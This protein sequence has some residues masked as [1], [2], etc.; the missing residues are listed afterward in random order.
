MIRR[1]TKDY[2]IKIGS[3]VYIFRCPKNTP[4]HVEDIIENGT[5]LFI[6][7]G[8]IPGIDVHG[9]VLGKRG[10]AWNPLPIIEHIEKSTMDWQ[11]KIQKA[12]ERTKKIHN[13]EENKLL[14]RLLV[15]KYKGKDILRGESPIPHYYIE[16][17]AYCDN[18]HEIIEGKHVLQ[19]NS[20]GKVS[21][22]SAFIPID[23]ETVHKPGSK[24]L[25][26]SKC[27]AVSIKSIPEKSFSQIPSK[28]SGEDEH[29]KIQKIC[30]ILLDTT[31]HAEFRCGVAFAFLKTNRGFY[32]S[33]DSNTQSN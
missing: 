16:S 10:G 13:A 1:D 7:D 18:C 11:Y 4:L 8:K 3:I 5:I 25:L 24:K 19:I 20:N 6:K 17:V 33:Q 32:D 26:H 15:L 28:S 29:M 14:P 21:G 30:D 22:E 27:N 9:K 2:K 23:P 12:I 31:L